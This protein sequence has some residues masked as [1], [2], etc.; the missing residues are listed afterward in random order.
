MLWKRLS[1][2]RWF[3][4]AD[5]NF[6][7][8]GVWCLSTDLLF[9][10]F[11]QKEILQVENLGQVD[12]R[13]NSSTI[14]NK[15]KAKA[16]VL[17]FLRLMLHDKCPPLVPHLWHYQSEVRQI[18]WNLFAQNH[19]SWINRWSI[20][21]QTYG[22]SC[23]TARRNYSSPWKERKGGKY[24]CQPWFIYHPVPSPEIFHVCYMEMLK[25]KW[26]RVLFCLV[27]F[28]M[29]SFEKILWNAC[30]AILRVVFLQ[31]FWEFSEANLRRAIAINWVLAASPKLRWTVFEI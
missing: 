3:L 18:T 8:P 19:G 4:F 28:D 13:R 16:R 24:K 29:E 17:I 27:S 5:V 14:S 7:F 30:S 23:F 15:I 21:I 6:C 12:D 2:Q 10:W 9:V 25:Q 1:F 22:F 11:L 20:F 31:L 26:G